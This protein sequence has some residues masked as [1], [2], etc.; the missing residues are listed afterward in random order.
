ML[1]FYIIKKAVP[2]NY[3]IMDCSAVGAKLTVTF[4]I[5]IPV[6]LTKKINIFGRVLAH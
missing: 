4:C 1:H 3:C 2:P 5:H 6:Y